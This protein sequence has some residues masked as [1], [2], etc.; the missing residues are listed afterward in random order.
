M[1]RPQCAHLVL[2]SDKQGEGSCKN[3]P[4]SANIYWA[5]NKYWA[6][7]GA[8]G[9]LISQRPFTVNLHRHSPVA[10]HIDCKSWDSSWSH[11]PRRW[12]LQKRHCHQHQ[13]LSTASGG[14]RQ[15]GGW[16]LSPRCSTMQL[17][18]QMSHTII[19][20]KFQLFFQLH[21]PPVMK[22]KE[23]YFLINMT[24]ISGEFRC[25]K[26]DLRGEVGIE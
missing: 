2:G 18:M 25:L 1:A 22:L 21:K 20:H 14:E 4:W 9:L 23:I 12:W 10:L 3:H 8:L 17:E 19:T 24:V 26:L 16:K 11:N 6:R 7:G 13:Q 15:P 5:P